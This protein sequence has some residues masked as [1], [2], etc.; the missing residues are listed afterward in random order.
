MISER[1]SHDFSL[2]GDF[3]LGLSCNHSETCDA[4]LAI[5]SPC[6]LHLLH[7]C[8][9]SLSM[10]KDSRGKAEKKPEQLRANANAGVKTGLDRAKSFSLVLN[11][12]YKMFYLKSL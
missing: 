1:S 8:V 12:Q 7:F 9:H 11:I 6:N 5:R 10:P 3:N 4:Q 2:S